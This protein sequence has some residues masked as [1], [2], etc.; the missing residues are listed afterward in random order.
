MAKK[1]KEL[2]KKLRE[3]DNKTIKNYF[4]IDKRIKSLENNIQNNENK[5]KDKKEE[6]TVKNKDS[7]KDRANKE[8]KMPNK[9]DNYKF[10]RKGQ[11][12]KTFKEKEIDHEI[13]NDTI[14]EEDSIKSNEKLSMSFSAEDEDSHNENKD[15]NKDNKPKSQRKYEDPYRDVP[16]RHF[17]DNNRPTNMK[18]RL[19]K[20]T[21]NIS[22]VEE[23]KKRLEF[24]EKKSK[25]SERGSK[26]LSLKS[27]ESSIYLM[28]I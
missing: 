24:L 16:I 28:R 11:R 13:K 8:E 20:Y 26:F 9:D 21:L 2:E 6:E 4:L 23:I 19:S 3:Q 5:D 17:G 18:E 14:P 7:D 27:L 10:H 1:I 12:T 22:E 15:K 25:S